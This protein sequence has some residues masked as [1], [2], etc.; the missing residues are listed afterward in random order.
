[1]KNHADREVRLSTES[2]YK[3]LYEWSL[4]EWSNEGQKVGGDQVPWHWTLRFSVSEVKHVGSF[5]LKTANSSNDDSSR[6][7][8]TD[9]DWIYAVLKPESDRPTIYSMF[10]TGRTI[11]AFS[12]QV[13]ALPEG[14]VGERCWIWGGVSY[15]SEIDFRDITEPDYIEIEIYVSADRYANLKRAINDP[16]TSE[17]SINLQGVSGFYSEW[18][19]SISTSRIKVLTASSDHAVVVP[20]ACNIEPPRLGPVYAFAMAVIAARSLEPKA[21]DSRYP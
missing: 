17:I 13:K 1:M 10:G 9:Q 15:T 3:G 20:V 5:E 18:S 6:Q 19:P 7:E 4:Q 12:L 8:S 2:E 16:F 11:E 14:E 21:N